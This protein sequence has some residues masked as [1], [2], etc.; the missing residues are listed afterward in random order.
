MGTSSTS[1]ITL[2]SLSSASSFFDCK[3]VGNSLNFAFNVLNTDLFGSGAA[4]K[5]NEM[6]DVLISVCSFVANLGPYG[7]SGGA[8]AILSSSNIA[9]V[10][11]T[12]ANNSVL[13][14]YGWGGA[15][16]VNL[17]TNISISTSR[18][19]NN[20]V[21]GSDGAGG[22]IYASFSS[23]VNIVDTSFTNNT[24]L[25]V[26]GR[27]GEGGALAMYHVTNTVI[28][29]STFN[30]NSA[31]EGGGI[32]L[33]RS[34]MFDMIELYAKGN[35]AAQRGTDVTETI[36]EEN[37]GNGGFFAAQSDNSGVSIVKSYF[38]GNNA[39][40]SGGAFYFGSNDSFLAFTNSTFTRNVAV[41][42]SGGAVYMGSSNQVLISYQLWNKIL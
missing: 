23:F 36:L 33:G 42:G 18:F 26:F 21:V 35:S 17:A 29:R 39:A 30:Y 8:L 32:A 22:A 4:L 5:L 37:S 1:A 34:S 12:F 31:Q 14:R 38:V 28:R 19:D 7:T 15:V 3:F 40:R 13:I 24:A 6:N 25:D 27:G 10:A 11:T 41:S 16:Y 2:Q 9:I 20:S